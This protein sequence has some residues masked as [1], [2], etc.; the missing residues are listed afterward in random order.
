MENFEENLELVNTLSN[1]EW[2][3][4]LEEFISIGC[5]VNYN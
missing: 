1:E 4:D 3:M 5:E 2:Q